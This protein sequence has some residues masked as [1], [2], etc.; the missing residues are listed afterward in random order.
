M[1]RRNGDSMKRSQGTTSRSRVAV[2]VCTYKRPDQLKR[3]LD[4]LALMDYPRDSVCVVVV[5]HDPFLSAKHVVMAAMERGL[6]VQYDF[7]PIR[8]ISAARNTLARAAF[9]T[10]APY[11]AFVDD[12]EWVTEDWL[13]TLVNALEEL[14][15]DA[16][17]GPVLPVFE[18]GVPRWVIDGGFF[19]RER[20][21]TGT[22]VRGHR[23]PNVIV[24]ADW[25]ERLE[26]PFG[27]GFGA[28]GGED[29]HFLLQLERAGARLSW[30]DEAGLFE[31]VPC[32]RA[33]GE[34]LVRRAF[35]MGVVFSH[36]V[37]ISDGRPR[38]YALRF[39]K[40]GVRI[41]QG[42]VE[43]PFAVL[44]GR[45]AVIRATCRIA[46]A[47]GGLRGLAPTFAGGGPE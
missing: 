35:H 23:I 4:S 43:M 33:S 26:E 32:S 8:L 25:L 38:A 45:A 27:H 28:P 13:S 46:A 3:L 6:D 47:L 42:L 10:G 40:C 14:D 21:P 17:A 19:L 30:C 29:T 15:V 12:D 1:A 39:A 20:F 11:V 16:V 41:G 5:D 44:R 31:W 34:W 36:V 7:E 18:A 37:R 9:A 2:A 22:S 24:R